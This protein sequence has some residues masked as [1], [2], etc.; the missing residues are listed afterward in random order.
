MYVDFVVV[1]TDAAGD[2]GI[3]CFNPLVIS[4]M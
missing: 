3:D 4:C 2:L 1:V